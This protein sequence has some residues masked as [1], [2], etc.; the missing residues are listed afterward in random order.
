MLAGGLWWITASGRL[1]GDQHRNRWWEN[2]LMALLF[3][4]AVYFAFRALAGLAAH[5]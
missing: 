1:I 4:F 5:F 2:A 3:G